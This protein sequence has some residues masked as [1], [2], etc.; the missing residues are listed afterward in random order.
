MESTEAEGG[1]VTSRGCLAGDT[2]ADRVFLSLSDF[3]NGGR[4]KEEGNDL[5]TCRLGQDW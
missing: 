5:L 1:T 4:R 3:D 2:G